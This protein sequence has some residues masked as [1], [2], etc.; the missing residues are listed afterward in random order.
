[1]KILQKNNI[2]ENKMKILPVSKDKNF[3]QQ[4]ASK[5]KDNN[6]VKKSNQMNTISF[7][8][9]QGFLRRFIS[10]F[11][12]CFQKN[13]FKVEEM[14]IDESVS[15]EAARIRDEKGISI[16]NQKIIRLA[17]ELRNFRQRQF[18]NDMAE[19]EGR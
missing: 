12:D 16:D 11:T 15:S 9:R 8:N 1:M 5:S 10:R 14:P 17:G 4:K 6:C 3:Q 18:L 7:G 2:R 13:S 19:F